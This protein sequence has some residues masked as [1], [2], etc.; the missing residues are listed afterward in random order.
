[1]NIKASIEKRVV[2]PFNDD[3]IKATLFVAR[4]ALSAFEGFM[5]NMEKAA[6]WKKLILKV[7]HVFLFVAA[8]SA[9]ADLVRVIQKTPCSGSPMLSIFVGEFLYKAERFKEAAECF[10]RAVEILNVPDQDIRMRALVGKVECLVALQNQ[11][12]WQ[13]ETT[14]RIQREIEVYQLLIRE[15][16]EAV[17]VELQGILRARLSRVEFVM[18]IL[19]TR[20]KVKQ[21]LKMLQDNDFGRPS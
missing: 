6:P 9:I 18:D 19:K 3:N 2:G 10:G 16:L 5:E 7:K 20:I 14:T 8:E 4:E 17:S 15:D 21:T 12:Y 13:G 11:F 1:M